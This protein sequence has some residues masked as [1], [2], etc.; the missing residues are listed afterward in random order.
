[1]SKVQKVIE[2][3]L[4]ILIDSTDE[5]SPELLQKLLQHQRVLVIVDHLSEMSEA[6]RKQVTPEL[7]EFPAKALV[8]TSRLD[9]PLGKVKTVLK[10]LQIEANRLWDFISE[11]LKAIQKRD[12]FEDDD[13]SD[14]CDRLR[15]I[16]EERPITVLLA[17]LF[18]DHWIQEREGA[19]GILPDSVPKLM[20][21]YLYRLNQNVDAARKQ[22]DLEVYRAA[23]AIAWASLAKTYR[24]A[25][26]K[27]EDAISALVNLTPNNDSEVSEKG[28]KA[29]VDYLENPLQFLQTPEPKVDTRII[30]DPLAEYLA[31]TYCVENYCRQENPEEAWRE[32]F[33][34]IDQ[35]LEQSNETVEMIRGFLLAVWDCC[36]DKASDRKIPDFVTTEL[37]PKAGVDRKELERIQEKRRI[38]KLVSELS[39]PELEFRIEA[40]N[41]LSQRGAAARIA[42]PNLVGMLRN[43]N[44]P[45]EARQAAAQALGKLGIGGQDLLTLLRDP[46]EEIAIRRSAAEALGLLKAGKE[47]LSDILDDENQP[48]PIRQGAAR[49]LGL[50]GAPNGETVPMLIVELNAG[51]VST[52]VKPIPVWQEPLAEELKLKLVKIPGGEFVMGSPPDEEARDWLQY[53]FPELVGVDVETSHRVLV[54]PFSMSQFPITQAQW[55]FVAALAIVNLDLELDPANFKGDNRPIES[56]SWHQVQEFCARLSQFTGKSYRL[57]SEAEWEYACRANTTTPFHF[58]ETLSTDFSNYRGDDKSYGA[59]GPGT[60]GI[61]LQK[62]TPVDHFGVANPYGLCDMHGNVFEWCQDQRHDS[63]EGAPNDG[64]AWILDGDDRY[65]IIRGGSWSNFPGFCRSAYRYFSIPGYRLN[66]I[67]FR[68]VCD[69]PRTL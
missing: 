66:L 9:E 16:A 48:L 4:K 41:K 17:R 29:L 1:L 15:R 7:A 69:S 38:R 13:H 19:G 68:V 8:V 39:A 26:I 36:E 59:Y 57:P 18:I 23:Q 65:R 51:Q 6:T 52:Q 10:P 46:L 61:Y 34:Q 32:F 67:G 53:S 56:V 50:I 11:Y 25:W 30:L 5:L 21:S 45:F 12:L 58:G 37:D 63:Y 43:R 28:A 60:R 24:P 54:P 31:A 20:L 22:D 3:Q 64:S 55:R 33:Q 2:G 27:K 49:A 42:E 47:E 62:T 44:Q 40:A 14:A 35:K